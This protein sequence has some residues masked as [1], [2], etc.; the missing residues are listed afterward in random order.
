MVVNLLIWLA[1]ASGAGLLAWLARRALRL[2]NP[3]ARWGLALVAVAPA[4]LLGGAAALA[5][6]G[7]YQFYRPRTAP[8]TGLTVDASPERLARGAY[9]A[10][11]TCAACHGSQGDLP[12]SGGVDLSKDIP[13]PVGV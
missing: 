8:P 9:L 13:L 10:R 4:L 12:L 1:L 2:R 11:T 7:Y 3:G 5:A 6:I